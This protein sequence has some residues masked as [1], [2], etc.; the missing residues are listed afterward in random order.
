MLRLPPFSAASAPH[1]GTPSLTQKE[2]LASFACS[3][4]GGLIYRRTG[5]HR[6]RTSNTNQAYLLLLVRRTR[7][8]YPAVVGVPPPQLGWWFLR[9]RRWFLLRGERY[10]L[11]RRSDRHRLV[12]Q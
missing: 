7:A 9:C 6:R 5:P 1:N 10:S 2:L 3:V 8:C 11:P 4:L 12:Q